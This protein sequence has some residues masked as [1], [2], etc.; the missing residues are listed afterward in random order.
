MLLK[1]FYGV[2]VMLSNAPQTAWKQFGTALTLCLIFQCS[3]S[4]NRTKSGIMKHFHL[5]GHLPE[6][7]GSLFVLL[8]FKPRSCVVVRWTVPSAA[9]CHHDN[10][11][12]FNFHIYIYVYVIQYLLYAT[13]AV[14]R[15]VTHLL[16]GWLLIRALKDLWVWQT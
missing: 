9:L 2:Y 7:Q 1:A 16:V 11:T 8:L 3:Y 6:C 4:S 13:L 14:D 15:F 12:C 10:F 5:I